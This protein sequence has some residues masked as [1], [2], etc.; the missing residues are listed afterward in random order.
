MLSDMM[1]GLSVAGRDIELV[2][3]L[4]SYSTIGW[5]GSIHRHRGFSGIVM[6][7]S[8]S[9]I[10]TSF[11]N[12]QKNTVFSALRYSII[13]PLL[14]SSLVKSFIFYGVGIS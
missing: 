8:T 12:D 11:E 4:F 13:P 6:G 7:P 2:A 9:D 10:I 3:E 5:T 14:V 1:I